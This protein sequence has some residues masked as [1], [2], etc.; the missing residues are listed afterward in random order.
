MLDQQYFANN[1]YKS[2][3]SENFIVFHAVRDEAEGDKLY[4]LYSI[5]ATPTV[6]ILTAEGEEID[7][8]V[9]F[10][11]AE[12]FHENLL[13]SSGGENTYRKLL[14]RF[15]AD[16]GD[17]L[18]GFKLARKY[19]RMY[20]P[21]KTE[22]AVGIYK[23]I[24]DSPE[25]AKSLTAEYGEEDKPVSLYE[26]AWYGY[27]TASMSADRGAKPEAL[28]LFLEKFPAS[29]LATD[30]YRRLNSYYAYT[31]SP[32]EGKSYFDGLMQK[33]PDDPDMLY[34]YVN[35]CMRKEIDLDKA[36]DAAEK[37][38]DETHRSIY[39]QMNTYARALQAAG[40]TE[41]LEKE[42]GTDYIEG[43]ISNL[44]REISSYASFWLQQK[45]NLASV[46][47]SL[48]TA[49]RIDPEY[50][51][52]KSMLAETYIQ[53]G[54][55]EEALALYGSDYVY[56]NLENSNAMYSYAY[57]WADQGKNLESALFAAERA[58]QLKPKYYTYNALANVY[59]KMK[60][61]DEAIEAVEA[62]LQLQQYPHLTK[63]L[64]DLKKEK[65]AGQ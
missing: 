64:E 22:L 48:E 42:Y 16:P 20:N 17:L 43:R 46:E 24:I 53:L 19:E 10:G 12:S 51:R 54:R 21:E 29:I 39:Y 27:G 32:E 14:E 23:S 45:K 50:Y 40:E 61:Y 2:Y 65:A 11:D 62:A 18:T 59:R 26:Y 47:K 5:R 25:K 30:A 3:L 7:R 15:T 1:T 57:F 33:Y 8:I 52:F 9:G 38:V 31:A 35:F 37:M 60:K 28:I 49:L 36:A 63:L 55:D 56:D 44:S 34:Y 6:L 4:D 58:V 41:K 13:A